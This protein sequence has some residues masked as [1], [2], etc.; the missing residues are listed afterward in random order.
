[1]HDILV[2]LREIFLEWHA[3][4][5]NSLFGCSFGLG[6][7]LAGTCMNSLSISKVSIKLD[8][9]DGKKFAIS[10][11]MYLENR[12][13]SC[14]IAQAMPSTYERS[15]VFVTELSFPS[16]HAKGFRKPCDVHLGKK[17]KDG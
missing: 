3:E 14:A 5:K 10:S 2:A 4:Q 13:T 6:K 7:G 12:R 11:R 1:M 9:Q 17:C 15:T 16:L 8:Y